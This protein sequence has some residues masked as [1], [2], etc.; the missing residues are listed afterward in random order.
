[1]YSTTGRRVMGWTNE[2]QSHDI[3]ELVLMYLT[4]LAKA[5]VFGSGSGQNRH[6]FEACQGLFLYHPLHCGLLRLESTEGG[7]LQSAPTIIFSIEFF[8][9]CK[10]SSRNEFKQLTLRRYLNEPMR[11]CIH[12]EEL[13]KQHELVMFFS[14]EIDY[15][16]QRLL[17]M[18]HKYNK[19][20]ATLQR[21]FV[22]LSEDI[23][24]RNQRL[25][26]MEHLYDQASANVK[27]VVEEKRLLHDAY[28][29]GMYELHLF[30]IS[31]SQLP[32]KM[33]QPYEFTCCQS[34]NSI[35]GF[36]TR[37]DH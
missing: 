9:I 13:K 23:N 3:L 21:L 33:F 6:E 8:E 25:L 27:S 2:L 4:G 15:K 34:H 32:K 7:A 29:K 18:E 22:N 16:N 20:A 11:K 28:T 5:P 17:E 35:L 14:K 1:M 30:I 36:S 12:K 31:K 19:T 26:E 24:S 37:S 10:K